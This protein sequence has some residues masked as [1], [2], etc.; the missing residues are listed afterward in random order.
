[1]LF[2]TPRFPRRGE[3]LLGIALASI[4]TQL[5]AGNRRS[6]DRLRRAARLIRLCKAV[7]YFTTWENIIEFNTTTRGHLSN[8]CVG[9]SLPWRARL[10]GVDLQQREQQARVFATRLPLSEA[11]HLDEVVNAQDGDCSLSC[12]PEL[13][14]LQQW[15]GA[16][17]RDSHVPVR[18]VEA[19]IRQ[20]L[21]LDIAGS[22]TPAAM[23]FTTCSGHTD[24]IAGV[25][26]GANAGRGT[27][28]HVC[29]NV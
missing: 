9:P 8:F 6:G 22:T 26:Q 1:M 27:S 21:T 5:N 24:G 13:L 17:G 28:M 4:Q 15:A 10:W 23:L 11:T 16:K 2:N 18:R 3:N 12:K 20:E 7:W 19:S 29:Q 14:H 25:N